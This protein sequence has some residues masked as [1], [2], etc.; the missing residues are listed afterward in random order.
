[1]KLSKLS[2]IFSATLLL[3]VSINGSISFLVLSAFNR[4]AL[5]R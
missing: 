3:I 4:V 1:M 2:L 5:R